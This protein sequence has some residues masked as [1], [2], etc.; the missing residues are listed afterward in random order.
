MEQKFALVLIAAAASLWGIIG[1]FVSGLYEMGFTAT[2]VVAIRAIS[3]SCFLVLYAL[4]KN[5]HSLK[6]KVVDSK[7]FIGTGIISIVLFNWCLFKAIEE[8]SISVAT[9]LLYTAP[10]FVTLF[11]RI[12][13]KEALTPRKIGALAITLV[14][15]SLVIGVLPG[16]NETISF[17]GLLLGLGAGLFY[18]LYSIFGKYALQKYDS[19]TVTV[20]TFLFAA[21]AITP[22]SGIWQMT[23]LLQNPSVWLYAFGIGLFS[24]VLPF[25][26]YTKG[27]EIIESSRAS[28][29][30]TIE[31]VVAVV[32][33]IMIF[34][35]HLNLW[36]YIGISFVIG[37]V[38]L[39]R[40]TKKQ[41]ESVPTATLTKLN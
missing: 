2:Q 30:A 9:I 37:A 35:E 38:L 13:F 23:S 11:S 33:G 27:L 21:A 18:A 28:I 19:L 31:P 12:L 14:G 15:C 17:Y 29:I 8:T 32:V 26:F 24:T 6:I 3:A 34:S 25:L 22:F 36:Q 10:V 41:S 40:E 16:M 5:R 39:V 4:L 7:Y 20:F 1:L